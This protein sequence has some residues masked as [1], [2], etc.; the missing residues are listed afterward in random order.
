LEKRAVLAFNKID[1]PLALERKPSISH[2]PGLEDREVFFISS[3]TGKGLGPLTRG[4]FRCI[5]ASRQE[6]EPFPSDGARRG[7]V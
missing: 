2:P 1:L 7:T 5:R 3:L 6:Q 4:L